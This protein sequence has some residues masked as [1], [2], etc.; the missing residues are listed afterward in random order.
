M[1]LPTAYLTSTRN[2]ADILTAMQTAQAPK[3]FLARILGYVIRFHD[4]DVLGPG[5]FFCRQLVT[6]TYRN[7]DQPG[8]KPID[9]SKRMQFLETIQ[10]DSLKDLHRIFTLQTPF[11]RNRVDKAAI[12]VYKN[13]PCVALSI[14]TSL[15]QLRITSLAH[16]R[17]Y[18]SI[19][20]R[21]KT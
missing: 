15:D 7:S 12:A 16:S 5:S 18:T 6:F 2:L 17:N 11:K 13:F 20:Y 14:Q 10:P 3:Q 8:L 9:I 4:L 19:L 21:S 1:A